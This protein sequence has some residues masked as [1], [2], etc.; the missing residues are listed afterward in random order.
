LLDNVIQQLLSGA[1]NINTELSRRAVRVAAW[2]SEPARW[3]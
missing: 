1:L 3:A 2:S